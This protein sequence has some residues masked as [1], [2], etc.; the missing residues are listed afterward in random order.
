MEKKADFDKPLRLWAEDVAPKEAIGCKRCEL[1]KHGGEIVWGEGNP[2]AG[3]VVLLDNPGARKNKCGEQFV[4]GTRETLYRTI[5][6]V[7]LN[8]NDVYL[9]FVLRCRPK[10]KYDK[11][12]ARNTCIKFLRSQLLSIKPK[13]IFCLGNVSAQWYLNNHTITIKELRGKIHHGDNVFT[14]YSYHP[15]AIRRRPSLLHLFI[16]DWSLV[17][18]FYHSEPKD[19]GSDS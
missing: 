17:A 11:D 4:C 13:V 12:L 6:K 16:E 7:G 9:T 2:Q 15:L 18:D 1:Y 10:K 14:A 8:E 5:S 3:I 19:F